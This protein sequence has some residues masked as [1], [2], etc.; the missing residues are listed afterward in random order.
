MQRYYFDIEDGRDSPDRDGTEI[1][2]LQGVRRAAVEFLGQML[3]DRSATF[4]D[5]SELRLTVRTQDD[6]R[7]LR[8][9]VLGTRIPD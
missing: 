6:R 8:L 7:L 3:C 1:A 5:H 2:T 4:W 9:T